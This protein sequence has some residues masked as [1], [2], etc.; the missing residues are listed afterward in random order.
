MRSMTLLID[1]ME[2]KAMNLIKSYLPCAGANYYTSIRRLLSRRQLLALV[3]GAWGDPMTL[4]LFP[5]LK[6]ARAAFPWRALW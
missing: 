2:M 3:H 4:E 5:S 6:Q 1:G